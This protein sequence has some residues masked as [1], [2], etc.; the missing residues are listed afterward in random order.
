M[1]DVFEQTVLQIWLYFT[2]S[3]IVLTNAYNELHTSALNLQ[4]IGNDF[5]T[6]YLNLFVMDVGICNSAVMKPSNYN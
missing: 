2:L 5:K 3:S 4:P 1:I 6:N